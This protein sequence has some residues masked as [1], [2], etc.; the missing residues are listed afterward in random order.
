MPIHNGTMI[1]CDARITPWILGDCALDQL[2]SALWQCDIPYIV[3]STAGNNRS[4]LVPRS[5]RQ[6]LP[7]DVQTE[8]ARIVREHKFGGVKP[9]EM[10]A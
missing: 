5:F 6:R 9:K 3:Q 2:E 8:M 1:A 4:I 7:V 10:L